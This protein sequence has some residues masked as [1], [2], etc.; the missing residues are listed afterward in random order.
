MHTCTAVD[1]DGRP[2]LCWHHS[3]F[4]TTEVRPVTK[5]PLLLVAFGPL[6]ALDHMSWSWIWMGHA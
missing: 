4:G 6:L 3:R 1:W 5:A 2:L